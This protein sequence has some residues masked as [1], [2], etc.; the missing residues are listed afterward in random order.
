MKT[1]KAL[2]VVITILLIIIVSLTLVGGCIDDDGDGNDNS[3]NWTPKPTMSYE[4]Y[5]SSDH[6]TI[7][8]DNSFV[9]H[10]THEGVYME[11][12]PTP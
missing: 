10:P 8:S 7:D 3:T 2:R 9:P 12:T 4:D 1:R 11:V 6:P 5:Q